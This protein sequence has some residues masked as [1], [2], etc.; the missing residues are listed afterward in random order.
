MEIN[1]KKIEA[2]I[3]D[4][5]EYIYDLIYMYWIFIV[6]FPICLYLAIK[7][8]QTHDVVFPFISIAV[9]VFAGMAHIGRSRIC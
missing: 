4:G 3:I 8:I 2:R 6:A 5:F 7:Y 9:M 1:I